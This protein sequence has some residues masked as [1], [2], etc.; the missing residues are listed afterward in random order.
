MP[1]QAALKRNDLE[2]KRLNEKI[3]W[4]VHN[5][6][7]D[8]VSGFI[9]AQNLKKKVVSASDLP[10]FSYDVPEK[11]TDLLT[12]D[13]A[14]KTFAAKVRA[15]LEGVLRDYE[16]GDK[17]TLKEIQMTLAELDFQEGKLDSA[18]KR[19]GLIIDLEEKPE[20]KYLPDLF[21]IQI[22]ANAQKQSGATS[23]EKFLEALR[24]NLAETLNA[25]PDSVFGGVKEFRSAYDLLT[26]N[27]QEVLSKRDSRRKP[28][29]T[30]INYLMKM[31]IK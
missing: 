1:A 6:A 16:I 8:L 7:L 2:A 14:Y 28:K 21:D 15:D 13:A 3:T 30:A 10:R 5:F 29:R 19:F 9:W 26:K 25:L 20:L 24:R 11:L 18:F 23:G 22:I 17:T 27:L 4:H 12:N 31:L